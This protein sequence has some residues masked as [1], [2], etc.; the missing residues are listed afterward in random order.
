MDIYINSYEEDT[1][2]IIEKLKELSSSGIKNYSNSVEAWLQSDDH[3]VDCEEKKSILKQI[4][5]NSHVGM[6][7]GSAGTGKTRLINHI[8]N[9][10]KDQT[11][12]FLANTNPA[13][14]NLER[15]ISIGNSTFKTIASFLR[16]L[17]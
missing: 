9:F 3:G 15:R 1:L 6:I 11:K 5:T 14:N 12:L 2:H 7:Y 16:V 10:Y 4:F 13:V 8:S 17:L